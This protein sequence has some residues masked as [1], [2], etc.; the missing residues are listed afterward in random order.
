MQRV[1]VSGAMKRLLALSLL[2]LLAC[3][4]GE[5][6]P[7]A[8]KISKNP[9]SVRGWIAD[10]EGAN[11]GET[12][13]A[14]TEG[15]RLI[16]QFQAT[17]VW[18]EGVDYVSGGV[19]ETGAFLLLDVPPGNVTISFNAP[20]AEDAKLV[21][22][23]IPGNADVLVPALLLKR[24]GSTLLQP[25]GVTVR[26]P[27]RI[28]QPKA[29]GKQAMVAGV[30]VPIVDTPIAAFSDRRDYPERGLQPLATVR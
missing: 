24:G 5:P 25:G 10:V 11:R 8:Q 3:S 30:P 27:A 1:V 17:T 22:Q 9:I 13:T 28:D 16:Q 26:V 20:G 4:G 15:A 6:K 29:T 19:A 18:V 2:A 23:N 21:L 7:A 12:Q 14:E